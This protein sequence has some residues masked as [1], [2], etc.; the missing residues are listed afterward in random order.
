VRQEVSLF[1][2]VFYA[3][4]QASELPAMKV[5]CSILDLDWN[6]NVALVV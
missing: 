4:S 1:C 2:D 6:R 5:V 3:M